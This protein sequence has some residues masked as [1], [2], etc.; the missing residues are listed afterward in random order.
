MEKTLAELLRKR[1]EEIGKTMQQVAKDCGSGMNVHR[2]EK[3][4]VKKPSAETLVK[5][6]RGYDIP[7]NE[8]QRF[9]NMSLSGVKAI[10][11]K[12]KV[13]ENIMPLIQMIVA[14]GLDDVSQDEI[15]FL[16][17]IQGVLTK[18]MDANLVKQLLIHRRGEVDCI[19]PKTKAQSSS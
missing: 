9:A 6:S 8:L 14:C 17:Q 18:P 10:F 7:L 16:T 13:E 3:G 15:G 2:L 5:L 4:Y 12:S 1:R 19:H 11:K